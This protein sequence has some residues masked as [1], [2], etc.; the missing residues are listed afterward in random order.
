MQ[1]FDK[2]LHYSYFTGLLLQFG[3]SQQC[4]HQ[5]YV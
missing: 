4:K 5:N 1:A 3:K 2:G